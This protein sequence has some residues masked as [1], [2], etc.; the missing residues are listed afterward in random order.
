MEEDPAPRGPPAEAFVCGANES[1]Q[2]L[3]GPVCDA[4]LSPVPLLLP[5]VR[6]ARVS[7]SL[8]HALLLSDEGTVFSVGDNYCGQC[9]VHSPEQI[10]SPLRIETLN[11][12][13]VATV[14]AGAQH[15]AVV[16]SDGELLT[17]GANDHGQGGHGDGG[18]LDVRRPRLVHLGAVADVACGGAFTILIDRE[19][20]L[21]G[22]GSNVHGELGTAPPHTRLAGV[23]AL[24]SVA[25]PQ[26]SATL[27]A[28]PPRHGSPRSPQRQC[29]PSRPERGTPSQSRLQATSTRGD[30]AVTVRSA[31]RS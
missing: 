6:V 2:L 18:A 15:S 3:G 4:L 19:A 25:T 24:T 31:S 8:S 10:T 28:G 20:V 9:G 1:G 17:F 23:A 14:A 7:L 16:T 27:R 12:K 29:A 5:G 21:W 11:T 30:R 26:A 13:A 22:C